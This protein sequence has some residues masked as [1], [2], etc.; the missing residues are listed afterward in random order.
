MTLRQLVLLPAALLDAAISLGFWLSGWVKTGSSAAGAHAVANAA[1]DSI[2]TVGTCEFRGT[3]DLPRS[4]A[5][6]G[7]TPVS[8]A[9]PGTT[10]R[11]RMS[12]AR[13]VSRSNSSRSEQI[14]LSVGAVEAL[15]SP[16]QNGVFPTG[17]ARLGRK[18]LNPYLSLGG[19]VA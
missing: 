8:A 6:A 18:S 4:I 12:F 7:H 5:R 1:A 2:P 19:R 11:A 13:G 9:V 3:V 14:P 15:G 17:E 10:A 16:L